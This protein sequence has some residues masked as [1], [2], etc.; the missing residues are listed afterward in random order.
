MIS[1]DSYNILPPEMQAQLLL[2][3]GVYLDLVRSANRLNIELY[4]LGDFYIEIY[5]DKLT[6]EPLFLK[7]IHTMEELEPYLS[8]IEID[9]LFETN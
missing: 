5:F 3:S 9:S 2:Q 6:E 7:A 1:F 4:A 8:L